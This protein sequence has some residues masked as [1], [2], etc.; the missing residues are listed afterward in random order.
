MRTIEKTRGRDADM[1]WGDVE[2]SSVGTYNPL[3]VFII[4]Y[5]TSLNVALHLY[6]EYR[7]RRQ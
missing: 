4:W 6:L 1:H 3:Y 5:M 7:H 2:E